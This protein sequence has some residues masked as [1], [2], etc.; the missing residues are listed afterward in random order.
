MKKVLIGLS[1]VVILAV[2]VVL[3]V[4][5]QDGNK[6]SKKATTEVTATGKCCAAS[7]ATAMNDSK[8]G[9]CKTSMN[10]DA[11][12][13]TSKCKMANCDKSKMANCDMSKSASCCKGKSE[14]A[15]TAKSG[16]ASDCK[17]KSETQTK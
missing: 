14:T 15:T 9:C 16:C 8:A 2:G 7:T 4:S 6:T 10:C 1:A 5:A 12:G 11:K 3:V 17:M 13:D